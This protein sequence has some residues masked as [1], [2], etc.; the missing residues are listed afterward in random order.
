MSRHSITALPWTPRAKDFTQRAIPDGELPAVMWRHIYTG[1]FGGAYGVL[2]TNIFFIAFGNA[3]GVTVFQWGLHG[4]ITTF[5]LAFQLISAHW[6]ARLGHR[7]LLW[8]ATEGFSRVLKAFGLAMSFMFYVRGDLKAAAFSLIFW[9]CMSGVFSAMS[10]PIWFSWLADIIPE[11]IHG[12]FMG[13]RDVWVS[14]FIVALVIPG[15]MATDAYTG[16]AKTAVLATILL[17]AIA[18]GIVDVSIHR[19]IPEPP[20]SPDRETSFRER[21]L[22]PLQDR[23]FRPWLLFAGAWNFAAFLGN[24]LANVYFIDNLGLSR[25]YLGGAVVLIAVP[26][27]AVAI[28]SRWSG[29]LVDR[30]GVRRML[31]IANFCWAIVPIFW[32]VATPRTALFWLTVSSAVSGAATSPSVNAA[33][34]LITR[35]PPRHQRAM[36]MAMSTCVGSLAGGLGALAGGV[37]LTW[38][39]NAHWNLFGWTFIPFQLLFL[40]SLVLRLGSWALLFRVKTPDFDRA[41]VAPVAEPILT[42]VEPQPVKAA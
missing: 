19:T 29:I 2:T 22:T 15:G 38:L 16:D 40:A 11:R 39:G 32:V 21:I 31:A 26:L 37:F 23:K 28:T 36:Y 13:R 9:M 20:M 12:R 30:L 17:G 27:T 4:A 18:L 34:K 8:W 3:L 24:T 41:T 10:Q 7:K 1:A 25:N 35:T 33:N 42:E 6:A 5:A 14:L